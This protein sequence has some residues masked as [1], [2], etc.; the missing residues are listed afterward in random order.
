MRIAVI[1]A[2]PSG[3]TV[4]RLLA[5]TG[6]EVT[7][8]EEHRTVGKPV[9]CTGLVT[10]LLW[11]HV[12]KIKEFIL[13][14]IKECLL[15]GPRTKT[16]IPLQE[17]VLDRAAFDSWLVERALDAGAQVK[18][19]HHFLGK[20][21]GQLVFVNGNKRV[22]EPFDIVVGADGPLSKV[23]RVF[24]LEGQK[25]FYF[26]AQA[27]VEGEFEPKRFSAYFGSV[28]SDFFCWVVPLN[29]NSAKIG[30]ASKQQLHKR[31]NNFL[32]QQKPKRITHIEGGLIPFY[33]KRKVCEPSKGVFLVGDAAG[34]TKA[35]TGGGIITGI[36]SAEAAAKAI[37][38]QKNYERLL[39]PLRFQL[40]LHARIRAL[41][42]RFS[43]RD[44][45]SLLNYVSH[46]AVK[47]VLSKYPREFPAKLLL[48]VLLREPRIA[49]LGLKALI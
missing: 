6:H 16:L 30:L 48:K 2:G 36:I 7:I 9:H 26:G 47:E 31:F 3:A 49:I 8:Y 5:K 24:G 29:E 33:H 25:H 20:K 1:G 19:G 17:W 21:D 13:N 28:A 43:D 38:E 40:W 27:V 44:Y 42:N 12:P 18:L 39:S 15:V 32:R 37:N 45:D 22:V 41:L 34:L 35:T 4:A 14:E 10:R 23:A 46:I 11:E